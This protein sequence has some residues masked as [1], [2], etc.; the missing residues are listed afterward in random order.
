MITFKKYIM[1]LAL[2]VV[3]AISAQAQEITSVHG[4]VSDEMGP[5]M[6]A[7]VYAGIRVTI[8]KTE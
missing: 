7:T 5:L 4:N 2:M 3:T 8:W 1:L 6:G